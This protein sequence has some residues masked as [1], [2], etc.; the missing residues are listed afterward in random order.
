MEALAHNTATKSTD[1]GPW[2]ETK[3]MHWH[4]WTRSWRGEVCKLEP[5]SWLGVSFVLLISAAH[6]LHTGQR[7]HTCQYCNKQFRHRSYFKVHLQAHLR[8]LKAGRSQAPAHAVSAAKPSNPSNQPPA[9]VVFA[10]PFEVPEHDGHDVPYS[11]S[12]RR[13]MSAAYVAMVELHG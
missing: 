5:S 12:C 10:E 9:R 8:S 7:P 3:E 4:Q 13:R 6:R 1:W 11:L 2:V